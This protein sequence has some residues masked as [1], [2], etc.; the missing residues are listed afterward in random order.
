MLIIQGSS[1]SDGNT[2]LIAKHSSTIH[3]Q[4]EVL[5]LLDFRIMDFSYEGPGKDDFEKAFDI[6]LAHDMIIWLTPV[7]WYAMSGI[8]KRFLDRFSDLLIWN[9]EAGRLLRGKKMTLISCSGEE[10]APDF[11]KK[12]FEMTANYLG[13]EFLGHLHVLTANKQISVT[14][15]ERID[16]FIRSIIKETENL[17]G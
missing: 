14:A 17:K 13:M 10:E 2:G 8:M 12:P 9:K 3:N 6:I 5:D 4:I 7:Y 15:T 1:R 16:E 11:F